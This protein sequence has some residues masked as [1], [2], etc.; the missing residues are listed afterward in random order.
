MI[1]LRSGTI[2]KISMD[3][4]ILGKLIFKT[5]QIMGSHTNIIVSGLTRCGSSLMMQML[6]AGGCPVSCDPGNELISGEHS[7]QLSGLRE[8]A[9]GLTEGKAIKI[10]DPHRFPLPPYK[11]YAVI[12]M[13]RNYTEQSKSMAKFVQMLLGVRQSKR[14]LARKFE[15]MLPTEEA[16]C[17]KILGDSVV[18]EVDFEKLIT[19][20]RSEAERIAFILNDV[21]KLDVEKM[22][23]VVIK[24]SPSCYPGM[25]E[26]EL[27]NRTL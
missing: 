23:S 24:R 14:T 6:Y 5:K 22:V 26:Q 12:W 19:N 8:I 17:L 11:Q 21:V 20:P 16:Q 25:L 9:L 15:K 10:L 18:A 4:P 7:D 1:S 13:T 27:I 3:H 2:T